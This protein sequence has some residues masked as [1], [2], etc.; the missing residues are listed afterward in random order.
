MG[1]SLFSNEADSSKPDIGEGLQIIAEP[2]DVCFVHQKTA[3]RGGPNASPYV[4]YQIYFR[5]SHRDHA[6][7][8]ESMVVLE[9]L[10]LEFEGVQDLARGC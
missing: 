10:F 4:R 7:N 5:L 8:V 3:H 1:S 9:D 6:K 2:G